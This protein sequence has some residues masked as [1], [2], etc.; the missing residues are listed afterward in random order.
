MRREFP[1][2]ICLWKRYRNRYSIPIFLY[3]RKLPVKLS[4]SQKKPKEQKK[5]K[6][7]K[8][9]QKNKKNRKNKKKLSLSSF[10]T[11]FFLPYHHMSI[12]HAHWENCIVR[13]ERDRKKEKNMESTTRVTKAREQEATTNHLETCHADGHDSADLF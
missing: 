4:S 9:N 2:T 6:R 5:T 1:L 8:R 7:T 3:S 10:K 13:E 12:F 11:F